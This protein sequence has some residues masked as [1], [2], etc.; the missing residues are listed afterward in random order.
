MTKAYDKV[1]K[2]KRQANTCIYQIDSTMKN[3]IYRE[4]NN[5]KI[6][7]TV[8]VSERLSSN[9]FNSLHYTFNIKIFSSVRSM[10]NF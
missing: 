10:Y 3:N 2:K 5:T 4:R 6:T 1:K 7:G 9:N 8:V